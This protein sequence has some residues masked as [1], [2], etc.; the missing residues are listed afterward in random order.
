MS[1]L[2]ELTW[3]NHQKAERTEHARKLLKGMTPQEYHRYIYNQYVMYA[4][5]ESQAK[6]WGV[7][8]GIENICRAQA[9]REDMEELERDHNIQRNTDLLCPVVG[10]YVSHVM[11][12]TDYKDLLAHLYVRHFG[13][14]YGGQMI[15]KR[16]PGSGKMYEFENVDELKS[17]VRARL[18]DD[19]ADEANRC[20][21]FAM[22]LFEELNDE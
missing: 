4:A 13:D 1:K 17:T 12:L 16:N 14:M 7:I 15:A 8:T 18:D 2:K 9:I 20:F 11:E 21:E 6:N 19:M 10:R 22:E 5:L 3:E